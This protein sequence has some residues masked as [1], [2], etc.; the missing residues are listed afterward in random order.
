MVKIRE[1]RANVSEMLPGFPAGV[2]ESCSPFDLPV[3][4]AAETSRLPGANRATRSSVRAVSSG[5]PSPALARPRATPRPRPSPRS[6]P[7]LRPSPQALRPSPRLTVRPRVRAA[8]RRL[9]NSSRRRSA[10]RRGLRRAAQLPLRIR[11]PVRRHNR[12][13]RDVARGSPSSHCGVRCARPA[14]PR[15]SRKSGSTF[16]VL[17]V[18]RRC[19]CSP[20]RNHLPRPSVTC[21]AMMI[22]TSTC[23]RRS[24]RRGWCP[25]RSR[26]WEQPTCSE[27]TRIDPAHSRPH[28]RRLPANQKQIRNLPRGNT[29]R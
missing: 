20:R 22:R 12:R 4:R 16:S 23:R 18:T 9:P 11:R 6:P 21:P 1:R 28:L 19:S 8:N 2:T 15:P 25:R 14:W 10:S 26:V 27:P 24:P 29:S 7:V 17:T 5:W 13:S 3:P